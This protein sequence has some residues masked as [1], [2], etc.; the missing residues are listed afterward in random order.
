M[1]RL[2]ATEL[3]TRFDEI[4]AEV[5]GGDTIIVTDNQTGE[6][7]AEFVPSGKFVKTQRYKIANEIRKSLNV[8]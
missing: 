2:S 6:P 1:R 3:E 5:V 8:R 4:I 7:I